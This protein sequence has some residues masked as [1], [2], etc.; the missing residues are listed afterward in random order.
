VTDLIELVAA[1]DGILQA[2]AEHDAAYFV[3]NCRRVFGSAELQQIQQTILRAYRWTYIIS[4]V[5]VPHF[6][7]VLGSLITPD[8]GQRITAALSTLV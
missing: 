4:G 3:G 7:K 5:Q 6:S 8:Q 1:V 2:Q